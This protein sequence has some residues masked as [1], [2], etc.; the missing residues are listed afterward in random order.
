MEKSVGKT[1][2]RKN[3]IITE[4]WAFGAQI[5]GLLWAPGL[6]ACVLCAR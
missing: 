6:Q 2:N 5:S 4:N 1:Q 3:H